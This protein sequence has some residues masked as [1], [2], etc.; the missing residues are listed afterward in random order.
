MVVG[1]GPGVLDMV[2]AIAEDRPHIASGGLGLHVLDILLSAQTS[3]AD[4]R[5]VTV[6][7]TVAPVPALPAHFDPH[8]R[9][10]RPN[11]REGR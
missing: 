9:T 10:L 5:F 2:R 6:D 7:S 3:A 8:A 11:G 1:R 4:G